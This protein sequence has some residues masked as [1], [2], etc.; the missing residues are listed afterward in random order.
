MRNHH[1]VLFDCDGTLYD[2]RGA[3]VQ[4]LDALQRVVG[5][6]S[7]YAPDDVLALRTLLVRDEVPKELHPS[8]RIIRSLR[9]LA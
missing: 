8:I 1:V 2:D 4:Y 9:E 7:G 5:I 6:R 3:Y